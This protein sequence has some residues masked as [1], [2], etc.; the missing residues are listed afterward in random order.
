MIL[1][2]LQTRITISLAM[3]A[4]GMNPP[5]TAQAADPL[6]GAVAAPAQRFANHPYKSAM[7]AVANYGS[8]GYR[9]RP[10]DY[11]ALAAELQ[12]IETRARAKGLGPTLERLHRE[13]MFL[14]SVSTMVMCTTGP[15]DALRGAHRTLDTFRTW[16]AEQPAQ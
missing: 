4:A 5:A 12:S 8:C 15:A 13:Y 11:Q 6:A 16:V 14:L 2:R 7:G 3:L 1:S 9:T 10:A